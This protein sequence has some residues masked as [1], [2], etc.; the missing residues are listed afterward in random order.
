MRSLFLNLRY[1]SK[2][3]GSTSALTC[4]SD[5]VRTQ[6]SAGHFMCS[7]WWLSISVLTYVPMHSRHTILDP[8]WP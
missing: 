7:T 3:L 4:F 8:W 2:S 6:P 5:S 1:R